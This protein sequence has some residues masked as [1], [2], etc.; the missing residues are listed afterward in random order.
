VEIWWKKLDKFESDSLCAR[1]VRIELDHLDL[2]DPDFSDPSNAMDCR[3]FEALIHEMMDRRQSL[4]LDGESMQHHDACDKCRHQFVFFQHLDGL[5][6]P[7]FAGNRD[8]S[9]STMEDRCLA[10]VVQR[11]VT[12]SPRELRTNRPNVPLALMSVATVP[13]AMVARIQT[14]PNDAASRLLGRGGGRRRLYVAGVVLSC[15]VALRLAAFPFWGENLNLT[16]I[17]KPVTADSSSSP[18]SPS[19]SDTSIGV[20]PR[21]ELAVSELH[22]LTKNWDES[23][24]AFDRG[25]Q[26]MATGRVRAH[27]LPGIQPAVYPITGAVEAFRKNMIVRNANGLAAGVRW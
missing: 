2:L 18:V 24:V 17:E 22:E 23:V 3:D 5:F 19:V 26:N 13:M 10:N 14:Q 11:C 6:A 7:E 25:W 15:C 20:A 21:T 8:A 12:A 1:Y 4:E 27:Q 16:G 9:W